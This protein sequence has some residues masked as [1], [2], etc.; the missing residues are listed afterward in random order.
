MVYLN[1]MRDLIVV[2]S[3]VMVMEL[4]KIKKPNNADTD[5]PMAA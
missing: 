5:Y 1:E 2:L 3:P 4:R